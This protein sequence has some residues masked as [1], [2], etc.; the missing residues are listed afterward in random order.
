MD[1]LGQHEPRVHV[2]QMLGD[3]ST[4]PTVL[5]ADEK[6]RKK[7]QEPAKRHG[8]GEPEAGTG[9]RHSRRV[10][11]VDCDEEGNGHTRPKPWVSLIGK[12]A[13]AGQDGCPDHEAPGRGPLLEQY[14]EMAAGINH[15]GEA[16]GGRWIRA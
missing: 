15:R 2:K 8:S 6:L 5:T 7:Q 1:Q 13:G 10:E 9:Q 16:K 12:E 11:A 14:E 4:V 3:E